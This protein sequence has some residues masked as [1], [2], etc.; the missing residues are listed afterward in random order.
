MYFLC[1]SSF[2]Q[3]NTFEIYSWS[4][5]YQSFVPFEGQVKINKA[6]K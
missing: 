1:L 4:C 5:V 3:H 6:V 2:T